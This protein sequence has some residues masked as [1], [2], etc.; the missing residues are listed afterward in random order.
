MFNPNNPTHLNRLA[1]AID[2]SRWRLEPFRINRMQALRQFVGAHYSYSGAQERVPLNLIQLA[3]MIY[4]RQ[5]CA[6]AP[7]VMGSSD[8]PQLKPIAADMA[9]FLNSATIGMKLG[10]SLRM[11][12]FDALFSIGIM[13]VGEAHS[14]DIELQGTL[15][16]VGLP[17]ADCIDLDDF[18][19]DITAKRWDLLDF[20]GNRY[21]MDYEAAKDNPLFDKNERQKLSIQTRFAYNER[22]DLRSTTLQQSTMQLYD[23][24][25]DRVELWQIFLP[26]EKLLLTV[27]YQESVEGGFGGRKPLRVV[28]WTGA[29]QGP[30]IRL[31][32]A[33]VSNNVM[34]AAPVTAL[35]DL[36]DLV[37]L[38]WRKLG[39][40]AERQKTLLLVQGSASDD[41][42][43][44][45]RASDGEAVRCDLPDRTQE[46]SMGGIQNENM[47]ATIQAKDLFVYMAGNLDALGGLSPQAST[48]GQDELLNKNS[49]AQIAEMQDRTVNFTQEV[50]TR[51]AELWWTNPVRTYTAS[52]NVAGYDIPVQI[53]PQLRSTPFEKL[54]FKID[55]YSMQHDTPQTRL[56]AILQFLQTVILPSL[57]QMQQQG[58]TLDWPGLI[59]IAQKYGPYKDLGDILK[60]GPPPDQ[61]P[62]MQTAQQAIQG[63]GKPP[64]TQRINTRVNRPGAT[65]GGQSQIMQQLL[66]GSNLQKG[67]QNSVGRA[68]G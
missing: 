7:A 1:R 67:Q 55:P 36:H 14:H 9:A 54:N 52:R 3:T 50:Y 48:L 57:P 49:A 13:C 16:H 68:T 60:I 22:G 19:M 33:D 18:V 15:Q 43:R 39:R 10:E 29:D 12:V 46:R 27:P 23:E 59:K 20:L 45:T 44:I 56:A 41:A 34:P 62:A 51:L 32:F 37:N 26:K 58:V 25:S 5:L 64:V 38:M 47:L 28:E 31:S 4:L 40:Q 42:E 61:Q 63:A 30:Y 35:R 65:P 21:R 17:F 2:F 66:G 6:R 24:Y 53:P 8:D 11:C